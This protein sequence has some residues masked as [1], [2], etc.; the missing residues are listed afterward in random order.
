MIWKSHKKQIF[1]EKI[2]SKEPTALKFAEDIW[3]GASFFLYAT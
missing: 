2:W 3:N 1:D